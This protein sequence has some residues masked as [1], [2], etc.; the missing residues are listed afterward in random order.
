[1]MKKIHLFTGM[2]FVFLLITTGVW[3]ASP[4]HNR[5]DQD[6]LHGEH[7]CSLFTERQGCRNHG[8]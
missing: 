2:I 8:C 6:R 3:A 4:G 1:M 7:V 5:A